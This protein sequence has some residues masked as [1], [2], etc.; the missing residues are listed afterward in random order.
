MVDNEEKWNDEEYSEDE[1]DDEGQYSDDDQDEEDNEQ[2]DYGDDD[3][4]DEEEDY[5]SK[6]KKNNGGGLIVIIIVLIAIIGVAVFGFMQFQNMT[7]NNL[8]PAD[9]SLQDP[10]VGEVTG[11]TNEGGSVTGD[12][13]AED[14]F[15]ESNSGEE[16]DMMSIDF[17]NNGDTNV[18]GAN[19]QEATVSEAPGEN[20]S[21][22]LFGE[23]QQKNGEQNQN[24]GQIMISFNGAARLNPFKPFERAL[25]QK[26]I[27]EI[28]EIEVKTKAK[29]ELASIPFEIIEPP[30]ASVPDENITS[31]LNTQISGILYDAESPSA[32]V[33]INGQDQFV[34][35]GDVIS[36]YKID[37]ITQNQVQ[38]SYQNNSYV[39][40]VGQLFTKGSLES[41]PAVDNLEN[42][43]AGRYK[44]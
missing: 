15:N 6:S 42:K 27:E 16:Q 36:G 34:K 3:Y 44:K 7:A 41:Q 32:I 18:S 8:P 9:K 24:A 14:F 17:N 29:E 35:T 26:R 20:N 28:K 22:D 43:F 40:S 10:Q 2:E 1:L 11:E 5:A 30:E 12:S 37:S 31:L 23:S 33:N 38:I 21:N 13:A 39:A 25:E 4:G 19:G